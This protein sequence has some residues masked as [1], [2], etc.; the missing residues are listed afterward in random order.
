MGELMN[1]ESTA[2]QRQ[3]LTDDIF[4]KWLH[5]TDVM[6]KSHATYT[7]AIKMFVAYLRWNNIEKPTRED[8]VAYRDLLK[9]EH[10]PNT[11]QLYLTAVRLFF[12]WTEQEYIYPNIAEH[13]KGAKVDREHKK[14]YM[15]ADQVKIVL[16]SIDRCTLRGKRDYA[17]LTLMFTT[18][19]RTIS[20]ARANIEDIGTLGDTAAL[21]YQGKGHED[22]AEAVILAEPVEA[23][24][25]DYL[26]A[27]G[28]AA[29]KKP[30]FISM[31]HRNA[32]ERMTT[33][34][35]SRI[36][37]ETLINAGY[38]SDRLTAHSLRHTAATLNLLNGATIE[39]TQQLLGHSN[40]NTTMIYSHALKRINNHSEERI[41]SAIFENH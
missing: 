29:G 31:A 37:K 15:T 38:D 2:I 6:P 21:F 17:L 30:L 36:V 11:V 24:I 1:I 12:R 40:I 28:R 9:K 14:D 19:L 39:E 25:R 16:N 5:Y 26:K 35:I 4:S 18:G 8:I 13:I 33:R 22:K 10:K 27:R 32:G 23:A 41:A 20:I 7:R 34:S 3:E